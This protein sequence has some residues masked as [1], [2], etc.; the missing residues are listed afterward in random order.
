MLGG[1]LVAGGVRAGRAQ[2]IVGTFDGD[3]HVFPG[4]PPIVEVHAAFAHVDGSLTAVSDVVV[5]W[6]GAGWTQ[7]LA[8]VSTRPLMIDADDALYVA[9]DDT[10]SENTVSSIERWRD[11]ETISLGRVDFFVTAL[12]VLDGTLV[13]AGYV[14]SQDETSPRMAVRRGGGWASLDVALTAGIVAADVSPTLGVVVLSSNG[15]IASWDG[16]TWTALRDEGATAIA[17]CATGVYAAFA[18]GTGTRTRT[19]ALH[20]GTAWRTLDPPRPGITRNLLATDDEIWVG[21][22]TRGDSDVGR[23]DFIR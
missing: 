11:A 16:T 5:H 8:L 17:A 12:T 1:E 21:G 13:A 6:D 7:P 3:W 22:D 2:A 14:S 15:E 4:D 19:L 9:V 23:W 10:S 20:D 18:A